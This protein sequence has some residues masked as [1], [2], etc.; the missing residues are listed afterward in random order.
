M[1]PGGGLGVLVAGG[2]E[3]AVGLFGVPPPLLPPPPVFEVGVDVAGPG[4]G[5]LVANGGGIIN[6]WPMLSMVPCSR[7]LASKISAANTLAR[8]A[9][10]EIVSFAS[11]V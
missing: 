8:C 4:V 6:S 7:Q 9:K 1:L 11:T 2:P 10:V 5:V 3:V